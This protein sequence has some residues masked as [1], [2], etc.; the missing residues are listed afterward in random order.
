MSDTILSMDGVRVSYG[1]T[2]I[3]RDIDLTIED[4]ET[5]GIM[6]RNGVGKT[7]LMKTVIGLLTPDE[8]TVTYE[9]GSRRWFDGFTLP[10]ARDDQGRISLVAETAGEVSGRAGGAKE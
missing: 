8:G 10:V 3:L 6:G 5:V 9:D 7:T 4:G 1:N 2:P